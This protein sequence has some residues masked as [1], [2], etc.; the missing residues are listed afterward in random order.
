MALKKFECI[1]EVPKS[2]GKF[3]TNS[4]TTIKTIYEAQHVFQVI[5][6]V[7]GMYGKG[8]LRGTPREIR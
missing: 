8:S 4:H 6:M 7:E 3:G 2:G 1:I 5:A